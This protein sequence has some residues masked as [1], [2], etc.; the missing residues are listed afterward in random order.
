MNS[1]VTMKY[2]HDLNTFIPK[3]K[4]NPLSFSTI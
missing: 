3:S 4:D 2:D 1:Q